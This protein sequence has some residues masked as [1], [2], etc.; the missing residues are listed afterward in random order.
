MFDPRRRIGPHLDYFRETN[1]EGLRRLT[2]F[3]RVG[4]SILFAALSDLASIGQVAK[5]EETLLGH[6]YIDGLEAEIQDAVLG[7]E[8]PVDRGIRDAIFHTNMDFYL[9][10]HRKWVPAY[11]HR[12]LVRCHITTK[13]N[14]SVTLA[15]FCLSERGNWDP[16]PEWSSDP[17]ESL[18]GFTERPGNEV[19]FL[20]DIRCLFAHDRSNASAGKVLAIQ[21]RAVLVT[22]WMIMARLSQHFELHFENYIAGL[23]EK[24]DTW[25][26]FEPVVKLEIVDALDEYR[27]NMAEELSRFSSS[28]GH[29]PEDFR[30]ILEAKPRMSDERVA[31]IL[32]ANGQPAASSLTPSSIRKFHAFLKKAEAFGVWRRDHYTTH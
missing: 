32:R 26:K 13:G 15:P 25:G 4:A 11:P 27:G 10:H 3:D 9:E 17:F 31:K 22:F 18:Q 14:L 16:A 8:R 5:A 6:R 21:R 12:I 29:S 2:Y 30:R 20:R 24:D 19:L 7:L 28:S 23:A 1:D